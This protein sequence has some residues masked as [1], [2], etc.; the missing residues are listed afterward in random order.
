VDLADAPTAAVAREDSVAVQVADDVLHA[1]LA[2]GDTF[3]FVDRA[4][5]VTAE[6]TTTLRR[7]GLT[8]TAGERSSTTYLFTGDLELARFPVVALLNSVPATEVTIA[9]NLPI[10]SPSTERVNAMTALHQTR[11][12]QISRIMHQN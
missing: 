7:E 8:T 10:Q 6:V 1:H 2:L 3:G 4:G 5:T 12:L 11:I 9:E